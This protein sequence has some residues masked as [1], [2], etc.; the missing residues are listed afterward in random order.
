MLWGAFPNYSSDFAQDDSSN[1]ANEDAQEDMDSSWNSFSKAVQISHV[2]KAM[3][4]QQMARHM[5][6]MF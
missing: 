1:P 2:T 3:Y 5:I 4:H 6:I